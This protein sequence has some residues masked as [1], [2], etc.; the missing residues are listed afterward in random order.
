LI[1]N[2]DDLRMVAKKI[3]NYPWWI[4]S[5]NNIKFSLQA[6]TIK[7]VEIFNMKGQKVR[8][9]RSQFNSICWEGKDSDAKQVRP[10]I[11]LY[12]IVSNCGKIVHSKLLILK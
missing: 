12:K 4:S 5:G 10:G 8:T 3:S 7:R 1:E 2:D 9:L 6:R 11:Y